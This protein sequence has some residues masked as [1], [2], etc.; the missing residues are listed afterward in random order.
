[1]F[2]FARPDRPEHLEINLKMLINDNVN[3]HPPRFEDIYKKDSVT[4]KPNNANQPRSI[5]VT[6]AQGMLG[7]GLAIAVNKLVEM[8]KENN[9]IL[10]LSSRNWSNVS[11][12]IWKNFPNCQFITNEQIPHL[13]RQIDLVLHTASPSNI[14]KISS[15]KELE[16]ANLGILRDILKN[17]PKKIVYISSG[18]V[19]GGGQSNEDMAL[20]AFSKN[21]VRDWY[22]LAK[23][24]TENELSKFQDDGTLEVCIIRLFHTFGPGVRFNDGRSFADVLW[25]ATLK[26]EIVLKSNGEQVRTFLYLSDAL[27]GILSSAFDQTLGLSIMNLGSEKPV[28]IYDFAKTVASVSGARISFENVDSFQHSPNATIIPNVERMSKNG[29]TQKV[30]LED[31]IQRT[32]D[33]I[34]Y[35]TLG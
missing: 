23:L 14:T 32:I 1:M 11:N 17:K 22:P 4:L 30:S 29:W 33:W 13:E 18:E 10:F 5:L 34:K 26:K 35:S 8:N 12:L 19:Y 24:T 2:P 7:H 28:T 25:G 9:T 27:D 20:K 15:Y 3:P 6:G 16:M 21:K 31:G